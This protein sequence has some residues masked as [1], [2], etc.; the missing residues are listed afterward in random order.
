MYLGIDIGTQSTKA[1]VVDDGLRPLGAGYVRYRPTHLRPGWVEEDPGLWLAALRPAIADALAAAG[2]QP[3]D[4][5]AMGIS[6]QLDGCIAADA[7][8][9]PLAP[10]IIWMDRRAA[11]LLQGID[12]AVVRDQAGLVLDATHMAAKIAWFMRYPPDGEV[13]TWHQPVSFVVEALTGRR[14]M[15]R[16]LASTTMLYGLRRGDWDAMLLG[17]FG[18]D[19]A[20]LPDLADATDLAGELTAQGAELTG[21]QTGLPVAVGTGDDFSSPLGAGISAPGTA[22]VTVG[23]AEIV[24]AL[25][26]Q[27]AI[28][29]EMLVETHAFPG[30]LYHMGNPGWL[31]GGAVRWLAS[32]LNLASDTEISS[33]AASTQPGAESL[34]FL[35]ALTGAMAPRWVAGARGAFYGLTPTHSRAHMARA[36]LEGTAFAMRDVIDRL[37]TLGVPIETIRFSGGGAASRVWAQM[38]ADVMGLPVERLVGADTSAMGAAM[39]AAVADGGLA[40]LAAAAALLSPPTD[41]VEPD[42]SLRADYDAAY[43]RY[44]ALFEALTPLFGRGDA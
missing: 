37:R 32:V 16:G 39:L 40:D 15:D 10:A 8:G 28:D 21:L 34:T 26:T 42:A 7:G 18:V 35:P 9:R 29:E 36:V 24:S 20:R 17:A 41:R 30:G 13:V 12:P 11:D 2:A 4:V 1:V 23:T 44:R 27:L 5:R 38:R 3:R 31:S 43:E 6:G 25:S 22:S 14:V 19:P 33:L